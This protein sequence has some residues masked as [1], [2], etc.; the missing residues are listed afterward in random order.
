MTKSHLCAVFNRLLK[1]CRQLGKEKDLK[2]NVSV[3]TQFGLWLFCRT[4]THFNELF[5][6]DDRKWACV[7]FQR[8]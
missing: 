7:I 4:F 3:E 8:S 2:I 1:V 6:R 5:S